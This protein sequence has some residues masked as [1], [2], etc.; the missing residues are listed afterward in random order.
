MPLGPYSCRSAHQ[1]TLSAFPQTKPCSPRTASHP[2]YEVQGHSC[3]YKGAPSVQPAP[4]GVQVKVIAPSPQ[5]AADSVP[6][7]GLC[8]VSHLTAPAGRCQQPVKPIV[9]EETQTGRAQEPSK[10][11]QHWA[12]LTYKASSSPQAPCTAS[13][14][15]SCTRQPLDPIPWQSL[16]AHSSPSSEFFHSL[17]LTHLPWV[18]E[19]SRP[20]PGQ[21]M[22]IASQLTPD[23]NEPL[24]IWT[25]VGLDTSGWA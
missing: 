17:D 12:A 16:G 13:P 9:E 8:P 25:A 23:H 20:S 4:P 18:L 10:E 21:G 1:H 15:A 7:T 6:G 11:A 22:S 3:K 2:A 5:G 14:P 19:A 24:D